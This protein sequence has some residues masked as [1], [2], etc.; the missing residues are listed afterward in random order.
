MNEPAFP[1]LDRRTLADD[2][3]EF[4]FC[5]TCAF[6]QAC[7]SQGMDKASLRDLHV[8]VEHIGPFHAGEHIFREGDPFEAIAAVRAGTVK[9]YVIDPEGREHVLGFHLPGEVIGLNAI[10]SETYPCNAVALDTVMLCRFSF[11][12]IAVLAAR[13]PGLQAQ[14][15][16]LLSRDIGRAAL[17]A[18]DWSADQRMAAFLVGLSRRLAARGFSPNRFQLTMART[19]IANYLR[20]APE[21][22]SRV[23]RR[24]QQDGLL[25]VDRREIELADRPALEALAAP[26]LRD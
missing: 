1:R 6:S 15:F 3:D 17:L 26:V 20:L 24:F 14:L 16:R 8:L 19:D 18:G 2:G 13:L 4:T 23:L 9:T 21:T 7:L 12:K 10:D 25:G 11:P 5:S 22:V